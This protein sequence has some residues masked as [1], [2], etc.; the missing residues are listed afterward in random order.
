M[1]DIDS[2]RIKAGADQQALDD[3]RWLGLN[4]DEGPDRG[5]DSGPYVQSQR[6]DY[7]RSLLE[8]LQSQELVYPCVCTRKDVLEAASAPHEAVSDPVYPG[9]CEQNCVADARRLTSPFCWRFR[10]RRDSILFHDAFA[11]DQHGS[12]VD[13]G[14][15]FVIWKNDETPAYQLAVVADDHAMGVTEVLRGDDLIPSTYRQ[16][17]LYDAFG[18]TPP[19]WAH[20]PLVVGTD[21][22][23]L[24]KR[25]G[26]TRLQTLRSQGIPAATLVGFLAF[27]AGLLAENRSIL[28]SQ[29]L[30]GFSLDRIPRKPLVFRM[31]DLIGPSIHYRDSDLEHP[32]KPG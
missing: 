25:H 12:R 30:D 11:G 31:Q 19:A 18:W 28:P 5:G 23:R 21:G 27:S 1:E 4:W 29:L 8:D 9:T 2:P 15:D 13:W 22:R 14:G 7:Y 24:A 16:I 17:Q 6:Q 32:A 26:D 20:V 3:L 10:S